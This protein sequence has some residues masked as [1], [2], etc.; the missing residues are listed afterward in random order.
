MSPAAVHRQVRS[1]KS[2]VD[3]D[4][5]NDQSLGTG[6]VNIEDDRLARSAITAFLAIARAWQ[7]TD[8][9]ARTLLGNP[10]LVVL[11]RLNCGQCSDLPDYVLNRISY[12]LGIFKAL[13][14]MF[15]NAEQADGWIRRPNAAPLFSGDTALDRMLVGS[16]EDLRVVRDYLDAETGGES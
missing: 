4:E 14:L 3:D 5:G 8:L 6:A 16:I 12:L 1:A 11:S 2:L 13:S 15:P 10:P 9:E 7:L